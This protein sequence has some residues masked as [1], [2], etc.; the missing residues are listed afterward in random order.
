MR[1]CHI[2]KNE[3]MGEIYS[4]H[5]QAGFHVLSFHNLHTQK[6]LVIEI[7]LCNFSLSNFSV[8]F[9]CSYRRIH[10][11]GFG[12]NEC[13]RFCDLS[14]DN[15]MVSHPNSLL[16]YCVESREKG[17]ERSLSVQPPSCQ[18]SSF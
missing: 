18:D 10:I 7:F 13:A 6:H 9:Y 15:E 3:K 16:T 5:S 17:E 8:I 12:E 14:F 11:F 2:R 1:V 4:C